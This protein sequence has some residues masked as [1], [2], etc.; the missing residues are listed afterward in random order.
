MG[1][2]LN[3]NFL[4]FTFF[5]QKSIYAWSESRHCMKIGTEMDFDQIP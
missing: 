1:K 4:D 2:Q 3:N 5:G